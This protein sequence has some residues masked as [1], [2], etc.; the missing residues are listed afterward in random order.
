MHM[1]SCIHD[2]NWYQLYELICTFSNFVTELKTVT[3]Q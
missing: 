2:V 3:K 1:S